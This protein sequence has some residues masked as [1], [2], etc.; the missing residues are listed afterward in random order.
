MCRV[1]DIARPVSC[2][3]PIMFHKYVFK[4]F[5]VEKE[6]SALAVDTGRVAKILRRV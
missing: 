2:S 3:W 5:N 6:H 1:T 4:H